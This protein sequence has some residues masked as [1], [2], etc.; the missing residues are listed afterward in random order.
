MDWHYTCSGCEATAGEWRRGMVSRRTEHIVHR[1]D[2]AGRDKE[3][4]MACEDIEARLQTL[5]RQKR[6]VETTMTQVTGPDLVALQ[7][8]LA[9]LAR[10]IAVEEVNLLKS[11]RFAE[12]VA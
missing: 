12:Y 8:L 11:D 10:Q 5:R 4:P 1:V 9:H 6:C 3:V 2:V 7:Q